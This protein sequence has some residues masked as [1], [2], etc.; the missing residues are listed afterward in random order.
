MKKIN[1]KA[2]KESYS[3]TTE[4]ILPGDLNTNKSLFG[5]TLVS[6]VDKISAI[7]AYRH[8]GTAV[9]TL[10]IDQL[11]FQRPVPEGAILTLRAG[12][13]R[14]FNTSLEVGCKVTMQAPKDGVFEDL[15]VCTAYLTFVAIGDD[16]KATS[17][18]TVFGQTSDEI[19]RFEQ[20]LIRRDARF[21]LKE[22]MVSHKKT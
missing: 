7:T 13:N 8:T 12:V 9:T 14:V 21:K 22:T 2:M 18:A 5:G 1:S 15:H 10:S 20:A 4:I 11:I 6:Y 19:R 16:H 3:E 17:P